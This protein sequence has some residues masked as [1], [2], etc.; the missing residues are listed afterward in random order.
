MKIRIFEYLSTVLLLTTFGIFISMIKF[1]N[2]NIPIFIIISTSVCS[3]I[4][5]FFY[6]KG[7]TIPK[8]DLNFEGKQ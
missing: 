5:L 6:N 2:N 4:L 7:R 8:E 3:T 1:N